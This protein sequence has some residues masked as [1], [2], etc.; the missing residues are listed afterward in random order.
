VGIPAF[1][2]AGEF[3][4]GKSRL[5]VSGCRHQMGVA[6][7]LPCCGKEC[8]D[9]LASFKSLQPRWHDC[10]YIFSEYSYETG[11]SVPFPS[12]E[13]TAEE[14][15][16]GG[17]WLGFKRRPA[18]GVALGEDSRTLQCTVDGHG[19]T[20]EKSCCIS[21]CPAEHIAEHECSAL[22]R[23]QLLMAATNASC[24]DSRVV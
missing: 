24:T 5:P 20:A 23:R 13:I 19:E 12:L 4:N 2:D 8:P 22:A 10:G 9:D 14:P 15:S 18:V 6:T 3:T 7:G 21:R 1:V 16:L 11:H 17:S